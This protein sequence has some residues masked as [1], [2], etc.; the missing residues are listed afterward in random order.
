LRIERIDQVQLAIPEAPKT[1][2]A[3]CTTAYYGFR[4]LPKPA[5]VAKRGECWFGRGDLRAHLGAVASLHAAQKAH[6]AF[7]VVDLRSLAD[8]PQAHGYLVHEDEPIDGDARIEVDDPV[9]NRIEF[10]EVRGN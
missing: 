8:K 6:R 7:L 5:H 10:M 4:E 3:S 2:H 1:A 9:G